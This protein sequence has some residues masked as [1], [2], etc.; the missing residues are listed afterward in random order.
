LVPGD[1]F[2][3]RLWRISFV[4][5]SRRRV[6]NWADSGGPGCD[7]SDRKSLD[8]AHASSEYPAALAQ[9]LVPSVVGELEKLGALATSAV[10]ARRNCLLHVYAR[11][12]ARRCLHARPVASAALDGTKNELGRWNDGAGDRLGEPARGVSVRQEGGTRSG[13]DW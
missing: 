8:S 10:R 3:D 5:L 12:H 4:H 11:L 9:I 6:Q 13:A 7:W 2:R 1:Y